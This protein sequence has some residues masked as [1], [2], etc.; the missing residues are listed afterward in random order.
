MCGREPSHDLELQ[1]ICDGKC[2][3]DHCLER[4]WKGL[5]LRR[6]QQQSA[7]L[8]GREDGWSQM[9]FQVAVEQT[10]ADGKADGSS[11][12]SGAV[13]TRDSIKQKNRKG[14]N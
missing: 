11:L 13:S 1:I 6:R 4:R 2:L 5:D 7:Q 14:T 9:R 10:G 8:V 12:M 3:P